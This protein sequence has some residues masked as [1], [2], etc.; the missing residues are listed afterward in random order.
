MEISDLTFIYLRDF[1]RYSLNLKKL[2]PKGHIEIF[3]FKKKEGQKNIQLI[4]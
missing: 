2:P 3:F 4:L 1:L